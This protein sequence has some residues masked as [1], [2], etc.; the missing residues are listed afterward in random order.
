MAPVLEPGDEVLVD[1]RAEVRVG[2]IVVARHPFRTDVHV[3]KRLVGF[4]DAGRAQLQ[5][6]NPG[7][8]TDSRTLGRFAREAIIG[9]VSSRLPGRATGS[10]P[11]TKARRG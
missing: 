9:R 4:D 10:R 6:D 1:T 11:T 8:S 7:A 5:G 3:I 2:D